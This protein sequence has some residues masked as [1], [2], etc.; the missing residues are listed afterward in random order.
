VLCHG[1]GVR[2]AETANSVASNPVPQI[3]PLGNQAPVIEGKADPIA[4]VGV[5]YRFQPECSDHDNDSLTFTATNLPPWAV[6]D[7]K[8]GKIYGTPTASDPGVYESISITAAD[9]THRVSSG[10][11]TITV[12]GRGSGVA[13][14]T[15]PTPISKVDGSNLDDLAGY[16]ILYGRDPEDLDHS[17]WIASPTAHSYDF[18][19]LDSGAWYFAIVAVNVAG[20]EGPATIPAMKII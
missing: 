1:C 10:D 9:A 14:L 16:R 11:F 3:A 8:T 6:V 19:T 12:V 20:I 13:S 2:G 18:A 4:R 17:V 7:S 5:E 15:W